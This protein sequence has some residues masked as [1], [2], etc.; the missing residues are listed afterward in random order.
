MPKIGYF[1]IHQGIIC[2]KMQFLGYI[3]VDFGKNDTI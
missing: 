1:E 3:I 2:Q